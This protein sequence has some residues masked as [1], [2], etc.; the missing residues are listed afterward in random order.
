MSEDAQPRLERRQIRRLERQLQ[1]EDEYILSV[2]AAP[3]SLACRDVTAAF[4]RKREKAVAGQRKEFDTIRLA[5]RAKAASCKRQGATG[6]W[7]GTLSSWWSPTSCELC[8]QQPLGELAR[9]PADSRTDRPETKPAQPLLMRDLPA[10]NGEHVSLYACIGCQARL[11]KWRQALKVAQV[12]RQSIRSESGQV[13]VQL[14]VAME[15]V[16]ILVI[17]FEGVMAQLVQATL[18]DFSAKE[19]AARQAQ[20]ELQAALVTLHTSALK[21]EGPPRL[22]CSPVNEAHSPAGSSAS[23]S[24]SHLRSQMAAAATKLVVAATTRYRTLSARLES[25]CQ[26]LETEAERRQQALEGVVRTL[27]EAEEALEA[28]EGIAKEVAERNAAEAHPASCEEMPAEGRIRLAVQASLVA[29]QPSVVELPITE[30]LIGINPDEKAALDAFR[31]RL[32]VQA[33]LVAQQPSAVELP[34]TEGLIGINPNEKAA[35]DA[36]K[37]LAKSCVWRGE[38][39]VQQEITRNYKCPKKLL[40]QYRT[41]LETGK[42][43]E[44][45]IFYLEDKK[46]KEK[47]AKEARLAQLAAEPEFEYE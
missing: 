32:A 1:S 7:L 10:D 33:S 38:E 9:T 23:S 4:V 17:S 19:E 46:A 26:L 15:T 11:H 25:V 41:F 20:Y 21:F 6:S 45:W 27:D 5:L 42:N 36:F 3:Q 28:I 43:T 47:A 34:I 22:H 37:S 13:G 40:R 31:V 2:P 29:Q 44:D 8:W 24:E 39:E 18:A 14:C 16:R 35:L 12:R 30:G